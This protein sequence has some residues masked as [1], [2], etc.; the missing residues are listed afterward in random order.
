[1]KERRILKDKRYFVLDMDGT[2]YLG[3]KLLEG[4]LAFIDK[5]KSKGQDFL[6]YQ[7]FFP[8]S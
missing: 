8:K 6:L 7:Q 4:S 1:M 5:L 3:D 2:F